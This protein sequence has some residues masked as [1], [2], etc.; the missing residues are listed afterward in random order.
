MSRRA[1]RTP[2]TSRLA[3]FLSLA[4]FMESTIAPMT[5]RTVPAAADHARILR[6][7]LRML[8]PGDLVF[9]LCRQLRERVVSEVLDSAV[10]GPHAQRTD[11][12]DS[13]LLGRAEHLPERR[14]AD[15]EFGEVAFGHQG[16]VKL[17][18]GWSR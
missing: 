3:I 16:A 1:W 8:A 15:P 4:H 5:A 7:R 12:N 10:L 18:S 11:P 6:S 17:P 2:S 13:Q 9:P 14:A